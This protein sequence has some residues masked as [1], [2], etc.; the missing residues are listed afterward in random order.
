MQ[1]LRDKYPTLLLTI[2]PF[3]PAVV[4]VAVKLAP[5][6]GV[7]LNPHAGLGLGILVVLGVSMLAAVLME[8]LAVPVAIWALAHNPTMRTGGNLG[9]LAFGVVGTVVCAL[10]LLS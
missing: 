5:V 6:A 1:K 4:I 2:P 9:A 3:I 8:L 7:Q 10:W